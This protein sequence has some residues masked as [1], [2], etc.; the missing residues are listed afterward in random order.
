MSAAN[1][2]ATAGRIGAHVRWGNTPDRTAATEAARKAA[3][4]RFLRQVRDE[5]PDLDHPTAVKLAESRRRAFFSRIA[6][7]S[8][9]ARARSRSRA[10]PDRRAA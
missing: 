2:H 3:E 5:F 1:R 6:Q 9:A 7:K 4:D 8:V 10:T